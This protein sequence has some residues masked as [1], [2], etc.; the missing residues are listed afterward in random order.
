MV[1]RVTGGS[2]IS[3]LVYCTHNNDYSY[4]HNSKN[5]KVLIIALR[6]LATWFACTSHKQ[7]VTHGPI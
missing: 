6:H 2:A 3:L 1:E 7:K 5:L 4:N